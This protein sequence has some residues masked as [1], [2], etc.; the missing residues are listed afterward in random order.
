MKFGTA[1]ML[2]ETPRSWFRSKRRNFLALGGLT[3]FGPAA[4]VKHAEMVG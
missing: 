3:G 2:Y 1:A 4:I